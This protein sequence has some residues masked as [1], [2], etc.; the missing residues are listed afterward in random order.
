[1]GCEGIKMGSVFQVMVHDRL[2]QTVW[3]RW[4]HAAEAYLVYADEECELLLGDSE[5]IAGCVEVAK[6]HFEGL[7]A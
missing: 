5:S 7:L 1:M 6:S 4:S 2:H 3:A